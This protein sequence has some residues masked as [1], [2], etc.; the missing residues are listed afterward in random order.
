MEAAQESGSARTASATALLDR[1]DAASAA[2]DATP[3]A[4]PPALARG[5][6]RQLDMVRTLTFLAVI[7]LHS[8]SATLV[9][10]GT[11]TSAVIMLLHASRYAFV[12]LTVFVLVH[13]NRGRRLKVGRFWRRRLLLIGVPY[14]VWTAIYLAIGLHSGVV[15]PN[16][17]AKTSLDDLLTGGATYHLYF[18][19]ISA[20]VYLALPALRWLLRVTTGRHGYLLAAAVLVQAAVAAVIQYAPLPTTDDTTLGWLAL[21]ANMLLPTYA[22]LVIVAAVAATHLDEV[23]AWV[24]RNGRAIRWIVAGAAAATLA[25][26]AVNVLVVGQAPW[27][28]SGAIQPLY[29]FWPVAAVLG[30]YALGCAWARQA[31]PPGARAL[32]WASDASFGIFLAHPAILQFVTTELGLGVD[33][34]SSHSGITRLLLAVGLTLVGSA[35]LVSLLR[36]TVLSLPLVGRPRRA[37]GFGL[38]HRRWV[39]IG[40]ETIPNR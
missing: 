21:H 8:I 10:T 25:W 5:H 39:P 30:L 26:F 34:G 37:D 31:N 15:D 19:L 32:S 20:Q 27:Q 38:G 35:L 17:L 40:A 14:V 18:L 28:A 24:D 22:V 4:Q 3:A 7:T 36:R 1:P 12:F 11:A 29:V 33:G 16:N 13:A 9:V 2:E 6:L 23:Q